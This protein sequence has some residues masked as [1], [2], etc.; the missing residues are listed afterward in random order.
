MSSRV[1]A[2][3]FWSN[4]IDIFCLSEICAKHFV[5]FT[6]YDIFNKGGS[7]W[8]ESTFAAVVHYNDTSDK[9]DMDVLSMFVYDNRTIKIIDSRGTPP[10]IDP[11]EEH[12]LNCFLQAGMPGGT[13]SFYAFWALLCSSNKD[14]HCIFAVSYIFIKPIF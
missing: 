4:E 7:V 12:V 8:I 14:R 13:V 11:S 10:Q 9:H 2:N 3:T 5:F 1:N 6:D